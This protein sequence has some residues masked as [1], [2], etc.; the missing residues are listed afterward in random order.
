MT[1]PNYISES[2]IELIK[3]HLYYDETS[4][5]G[6]RWLKKSSIFSNIKVSGIA[7]SINKISGYFEVKIC[8]LRLPAHRVV[9]ILHGYD[10]NSK[11]VD[12]IDG[13]PS[14]NSVDNL[15]LVCPADNQRNRKPCYNNSSGVTGVV[16]TSIINGSKNKINY[17][18]EAVVFD[19]DGNKIRK[20]FSVNK[21]GYDLA[22][23]MAIEHRDTLLSEVNENL[24]LSG[25]IGYSD[26]HLSKSQ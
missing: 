1:T 10:V 11:I 24:K 7:G 5:S 23:K 8:N 25:Y 12:H 3:E 20:K 6:I 2:D 26:R 17:Y 22:K 4:P 19:E 14:N 18:W 21:Y 13:N 16:F 9:L 15:R